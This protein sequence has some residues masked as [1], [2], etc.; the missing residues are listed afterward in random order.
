M[1][2]RI[3]RNL[4]NVPVGSLGVIPIIGCTE[5]GEKVNNFLVKWRQ[6]MNMDDKSDSAYIGY[7]KDSFI[8][9][10]NVPRF[11]S[12]EAKGIILESVRGKDLYLMVD[13]CNYSLTYSLTGHVNRMSPDD[14]F[15]NLKRIIAAVGGKARRINVIMPFLYE[16]RQHKRSSRESLDCALALQELVRMGVDNIITFDAHDPRVSN[17]IPLSG[18]ET[19]SP[20]Y[21]LIKG[22]L[23]TIPDLKIDSDHM[24]VISPD[25]GATGRAIYMANVLGVDMGM[26]YKRRDYTQII[27][28]RNPI[29]AHEFLGTSVE[30]K[31]VIIVDDMISSGES[32]L[33]VARQLKARK[34]NRIFAASTFGLFTNGFELF[35]KA[36]EEGL[37]HSVLTTNLIYQT[38]EL[39]SK[40]YYINCD[41]SKYIALIIDTLNHDASLSEV[42]S[43]LE[44]INNV[45][46]KYNKGETIDPVELEECNLL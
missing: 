14:H 6:D 23:R 10:A 43:P 7:N 34:A 24:M 35:D 19:V 4:E 18:F 27:D 44:R 31:D 12:G 16:S 42:L 29:V 9:N 41:M 15:Q 20:T 36:Y 11:G 22:L 33:D 28:G 17:A 13:V 3:E 45:V 2:H 40:P 30:G 38:P 1:L 39:L 46:E 26:F 25:E 21:Q 8:I 32:M 37:I 5:M